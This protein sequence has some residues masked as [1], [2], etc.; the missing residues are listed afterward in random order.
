[1]DGSLTLHLDLCGPGA[2]TSLTRNQ[3]TL[4]RKVKRAY[5]F[6]TVSFVP[7]RL[8]DAAHSLPRP[9][10][11]TFATKHIPGLGHDAKEFQVFHW[12]LHRWSLLDRKLTSPAFDCGGHTWYVLYS[13]RVF[14]PTKSE[15][16]QRRILLFPSG[17]SDT[18]SHTVSVYLNHASHKET[19]EDWHAC[20]Q[21]V[22]AISNPHDPTVYTASCA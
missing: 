11:K 2:W 8:L 22:L 19:E 18:L 5:P 7:P 4:S 12:K 3:T 16:P 15:N 13:Y 1:M 6:S 14:S 21:F 17:A 10:D 9:P 20:A